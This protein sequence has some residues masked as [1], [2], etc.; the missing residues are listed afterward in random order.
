MPRGHMSLHDFTIHY[1]SFLFI[2]I[3][4]APLLFAPLFRSFLSKRNAESQTVSALGTQR[5]R[6]SKG[7]DAVRPAFSV[8]CPT[9]YFLGQLDR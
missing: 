2:L 9:D 8:I 5:E 1:H 7:K 4:L 6:G 3:A